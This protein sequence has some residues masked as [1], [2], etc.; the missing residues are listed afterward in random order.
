[1]TDI[2]CS[3]DEI[4]VK[5]DRGVTKIRSKILLLRDNK[6]FAVCKGCGTEVQIPIT[7]AVVPPSGPRLIL[8]TP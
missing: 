5:S 3:C 1:M 6:A 7:K 4:I 2:V 8:K